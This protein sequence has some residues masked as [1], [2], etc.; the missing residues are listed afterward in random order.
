MP[1]LL[2]AVTTLTDITGTPLDLTGIE[3]LQIGAGLTLSRVTNNGPAY[4]LIAL[5]TSAAFPA[6]P[7]A[8]QRPM[9]AAAPGTSVVSFVSLDGP[10]HYLAATYFPDA[11]VTHSATNYT[12]CTLYDADD[13]GAATAIPG[14]VIDTTTIDWASGGVP[15][16]SFAIGMDIAEGHKL[17]AVWS[18]SGTGVANPGGMWRVK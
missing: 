7:V 9:T 5:T 4:A 18:K 8:Y 12:T 15:A 16:F 1:A 14:A 17:V 6:I 13:L 3:A 2:A 11:G 10:T